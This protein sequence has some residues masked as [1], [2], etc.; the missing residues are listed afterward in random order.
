MG[1][2]GYGT[3][4]PLVDKLKQLANDIQ[5]VYEEFLDVEALY[6]QGKISDKEFFKKMGSFLKAF[7]ALG[8]LTVKVIVE[9]DKA[10][11]KGE[12]HKPEEAVT[13]PSPV[14]KPEMLGLGAPQYPPKQAEGPTKACSQCGAHIPAKAKFCTKCGSKQ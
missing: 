7:S 4:E 3:R 9:I 13:L 5:T 11:G 6:Q 2:L 8:F 12:K 1:E 14:L 10:I